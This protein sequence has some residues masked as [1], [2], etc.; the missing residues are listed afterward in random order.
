MAL[1]NIFS[2]IVDHI[3]YKNIKAKKRKNNPPIRSGFLI[4]NAIIP[5][6]G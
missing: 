2:S 5:S 3:E 6:D 4:I 1:V